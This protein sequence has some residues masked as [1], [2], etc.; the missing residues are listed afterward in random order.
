MIFK[1]HKAKGELMKHKT[2]IAVILAVLTMTGCFKV[3]KKSEVAAKAAQTK[4]KQ[5]ESK[6]PAKPVNTRTLR[7]DD[8]LIDFEGQM[9]PNVYNMMFSWPETQDRVRISLD[10]QMAF[11]VKTEERTS[12]AITNLQGGRQVSILV[13][14]LD[15]KYHVIASEVRSQEVPQDY[16]FPSQYTLTGNMTIQKERV[17]LDGSMINTANFN[18]TIQTKKLVVLNKSYIQNFSEGSK[19]LHGQTGRS[20][21]VIRIVAESAEGDLTFT[22]NSE[23]GGDA[24]KGFYHSFGLGSGTEDAFCIRGTNGF[25]AGRNGDL[26][27][28]IKD[29]HNF[30]YYTQQ[31]FSDGGLLAP[32]L[33]K[34]K[35]LNYPSLSPHKFTGNDC[36]KKPTPGAEAESG[37]ICLTF[38]GQLPQQGCE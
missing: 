13:E 35:D 17:F 37:N 32:L 2:F 16:M 27:L 9:Q 7:L 25:A 18:L 14:I 26:N 34:D 12:E 21:G 33:S 30:R 38:S 22:L 23:A 28:Q 1:S 10:G 6:T 29:I 4:A 31:T 36:P 8:V 11:A 5:A 3:Q 20:G 24:L 19:A 15:E